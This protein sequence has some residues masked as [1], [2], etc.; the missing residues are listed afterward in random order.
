MNAIKLQSM[1][2][3]RSPLKGIRRF[4]RWEACAAI[5]TNHPFSGPISVQSELPSWTQTHCYFST[6]SRRRRR[7]GE[8]SSTPPKNPT[9]FIPAAME[10]LEKIQNAL[11]PMKKYN[12]VFHL[13]RSS[14]E[15]GPILTLELKPG[16][17]QY[18]FQVDENECTL[19]LN[20]PMSGNYTY[21]LIPPDRFVGRDDGHS[22][23]GMIVR[24]LI[25]HCN[26]V[27]DF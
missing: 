12:D 20:S 22:L 26:G 11:E 8:S 18:E 2:Q 1:R 16:E 23:E 4:P 7:R 15:I 3:V 9:L 17:G 27:P 13:N 6:S 25:R 24:D 10:E 5:L 14:N 21:I 19:T